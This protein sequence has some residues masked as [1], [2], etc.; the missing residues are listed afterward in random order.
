LLKIIYSG[1]EKM[2]DTNIDRILENMFLVMLV[3]HKKILKTDLNGIPDNLTRLH[4]AVMGELSQT[5][6]TMSELA[7]TLMMTKPQLTHVV[8]PLV[9]SGIVERRPDE[10]DRR[11]INLALTAKGHVLLDE[12]KQKIKENIKI[13][14]AALTPEELSEMSAALETLRRIG[15]KL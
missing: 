11:V 7:K 12:G 15:S 6:L 10:K 1:L 13:K 3:I 2:N 9:S 4:M 14:L 8:D 5:S